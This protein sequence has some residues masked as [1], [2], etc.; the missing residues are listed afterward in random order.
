MTGYNAIQQY[1]KLI[2]SYKGNKIIHQ[3]SLLLYKEMQLN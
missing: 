2:M 3:I 1:F